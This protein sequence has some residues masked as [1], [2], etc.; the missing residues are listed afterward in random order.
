MQLQALY[1]R[2]KVNARIGRQRT[3]SS[4]D[5]WTSMA[6]VLRCVYVRAARCACGGGMRGGEPGV[7]L[8]VGCV[9]EKPGFVHNH[10]NGEWF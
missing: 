9:E 3:A 7:A 6:G 4:F 8:C 10:A 2:E 1:C 5:T